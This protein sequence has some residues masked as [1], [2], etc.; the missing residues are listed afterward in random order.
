MPDK[1]KNIMLTDISHGLNNAATIQS[2]LTNY[3]EQS[4]FLIS[5]FQQNLYKTGKQLSTVKSNF[6]QL[7]QKYQ[8]E[9]TQYTTNKMD[10]I[11]NSLRL[12]N[13]LNQITKQKCLTLPQIKMINN[14]THVY[15]NA[16]NTFGLNYYSYSPEQLCKQIDK[17]NQNDSKTFWNLVKDNSI[18]QNVKTGYKKCYK[19]VLAHQFLT[20]K[21]KLTI[22]QFC[23]SIEQVNQKQI[24][25]KSINKQIEEQNDESIVDE[26]ITN[27]NNQL[28]IKL[29]T[30]QQITNQQ[31]IDKS[32]ED[33]QIRDVQIKDKLIDEQ[34]TNKNQLQAKLI[35]QQ[36]IKSKINLEQITEEQIKERQIQLKTNK[37]QTVKLQTKQQ[38]IIKQQ[39]ETKINLKQI[40]QEF[41]RQNK[42]YEKYFFY[43]IYA[44]ICLHYKR[45]KM[46]QD[47]QKQLTNKVQIQDQAAYYTQLYKNGLKC[48]LGE[49]YSAADQIQLTQCIRK[50]NQT[51]RIAFWKHI[52]EQ[53]TTYSKSVRQLKYFLKKGY[54]RVLYNDKLTT[55]DKQYIRKYCKLH[56]DLIP[57]EITEKL[58]QEY[59]QDRKLFF[60]EV[61]D[62][63]YNQYADKCE[64]V[65]SKK[66][67]E[68]YF[69]KQ[70][71]EFKQS[72]TDIYKQALHHV[73]NKDYTHESP[74][75]VCSAIDSLKVQQ[76][77]QFWQYLE[78]NV[79]PKRIKSVLQ[80]YY[81]CCYQKVLYTDRL[82][83][84]DK[85]L[86]KQYCNSNI[87]KT[88]ILITNELIQLY[89]KQRS[90]FFYDILKVV[91]EYL[92]QLRKHKSIDINGKHCLKQN[93]DELVNFYNQALSQQL[94]NDC[95]N[96]TAVQICQ[97]IDSLNRLDSK[98]FWTILEQ[99][100]QPKTSME[101]IKQRYRQSFRSVLFTD[102]V[103]EK[104]LIFMNK[105]CIDNSECM[106][107]A[108]ITKNLI[109]TYFSAR[110]IFYFSV[111]AQIIKMQNKQSYQNQQKQVIDVK[112]RK[113]N[114]QMNKSKNIDNY[115]KQLYIK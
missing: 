22:L 27:Q 37:L 48:L 89:F 88:Y 44:V 26:Q 8:T 4:N 78:Q 99:I 6:I 57:V 39:N 51:Q 17:L 106:S 25:T 102:R 90:L 42:Q 31:Q 12:R 53:D 34:I 58:F 81:R 64:K 46:G 21:D 73:L 93:I 32:I 92:Y 14:N 9:Q 104:D 45:R 84:E 85:Q 91:K 86:I 82:T 7:Q 103:N 67:V 30:K 36:Q 16:F 10:S 19:R 63:V 20:L 49:D 3:I 40:T 101:L 107:P 54:Q 113:T 109:R 94:G 65:K 97:T 80:A 75:I 79:Q 33:E 112:I 35:N 72:W 77:A 108:E 41:I 43:D 56:P 69:S 74:Q 11:S 52:Q 1:S 59:F 50:L 98:Q 83:S 111:F 23:K 38:Q 66:L 115:T 95:S 96:L 87:Q 105:Y 47:A 60:H 15:K 13:Q 61:R 70:W 114:Y 2:I 100:L 68:Q 76:K 28:T 24:Q 71:S 29:Q 5:T 18:Q 62:F 55:K 110:S